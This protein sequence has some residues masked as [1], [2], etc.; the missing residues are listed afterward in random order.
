MYLYVNICMH[1]ISVI[2]KRI[3]SV[4]LMNRLI[5]DCQSNQNENQNREWLTEFRIGGES[6][7][8]WLW[9]MVANGNALDETIYIHIWYRSHSLTFTLII[10]FM[11]M[12]I[13]S[14]MNY[15]NINIILIINNYKYLYFRSLQHWGGQISR[16]WDLPLEP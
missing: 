14:I 16:F 9:A 7:C 4:I 10:M 11:I 2:Y 8:L 6:E 12:H 3:E 13:L 1:I 5:R 15:D